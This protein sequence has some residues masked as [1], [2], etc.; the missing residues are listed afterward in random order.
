MSCLW[1]SAARTFDESVTGELTLIV[2]RKSEIETWR[3]LWWHALAFGGRA[4]GFIMT[5]FWFFPGTAVSRLLRQGFLWNSRYSVI[6]LVIL[7]KCNKHAMILFFSNPR[8]YPESFT[9]LFKITYKWC[10]IL[11]VPRPLELEVSSDCCLHQ[12]S[13]ESLIMSKRL[14][15]EC[16]ECLNY[17]LYGLLILAILNW[18]WL[19]HFPWKSMKSGEC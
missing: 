18:T 12:H 11:A 7:T 9:H 2:F 19:F 8:P 6:T 3:A 14:Q 10:L 17:W 5:E 15:H 13:I 1:I 4:T 16:D